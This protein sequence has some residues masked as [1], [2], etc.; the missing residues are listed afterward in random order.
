M[1]NFSFISIFSSLTSVSWPPISKTQKEI[2]V[3]CLN[4]IMEKANK[5]PQDIV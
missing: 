1:Q 5:C 3:Y 2:G 4:N